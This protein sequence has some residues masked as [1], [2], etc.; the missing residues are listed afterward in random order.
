MEIVRTWKR[1]RSRNRMPLSAAVANVLHNSEA[2]RREGE[3][4]VRD[5]LLRGWVIQTRLACF[6]AAGMVQRT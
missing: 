1:D 3:A 6:Q 4:F 2:M 5:S